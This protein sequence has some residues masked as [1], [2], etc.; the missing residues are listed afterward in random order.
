M[1]MLWQEH[2]T[3]WMAAEGDEQKLALGQSCWRMAQG[4]A[5]EFEQAP[6]STG[7]VSALQS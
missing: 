2:L 3:Q 1:I 4:L 6:T 5:A 7:F